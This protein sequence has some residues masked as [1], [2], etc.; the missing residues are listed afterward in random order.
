MH[1]TLVDPTGV[2]NNCNNSGPSTEAPTPEI[3]RCYYQSGLFNI[4]YV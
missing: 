2:V 4:H 1:M 3:N